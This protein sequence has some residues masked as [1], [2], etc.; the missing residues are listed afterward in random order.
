MD[1]PLSPAQF[2]LDG[3]EIAS[4]PSVLED[5]IPYSS[6]AAT[7]TLRNVSRTDI[8]VRLCAK[9]AAVSGTLAL[10]SPTSTAGVGRS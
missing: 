4:A 7:V 8:A 9:N 5:R 6:R 3:R 10:L 2:R 1:A